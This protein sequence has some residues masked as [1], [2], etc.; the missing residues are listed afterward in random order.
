MHRHLPKFCVFRSS[1]DPHPAEFSHLD[2]ELSTPT[3]IA[4]QYSR[5]EPEHTADCPGSKISGKSSQEIVD[6]V[7][8]TDAFAS[9]MFPMFRTLEVI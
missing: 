3:S 6:V 9:L 4:A 7:S 1:S 2:D 8:D 5:A